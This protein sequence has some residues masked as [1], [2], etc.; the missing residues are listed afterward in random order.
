M[1]WVRVARRWVPRPIRYAVQRFVSLN[2]V[3]MRYF[4]WR[5][6]SARITS[7]DASGDAASV[8][9]G[10]VKNRAQYHTH[11]VDACLELQVP[12]RVIDLY[13]HDWLARVQ[14]A[15][16]AIHLA[17]P[18]ATSTPTAKVLK[19]RL[20]LLERDLGQQV[21]PSAAERW[22]YEDKIRTADWLTAHRLP[23]PATWVF[24][25]R[26]EAEAFATTCA[27]PIVT[28]TS[29]GA[30]ATGVRLLR[31]RRQVLATVA[32]AFGPGVTANGADRRDRQ[33]GRILLQ[34]HVD[35]LREW[36]MVRIGDA[37]FGHPKGRR[38]DF[39]SGSGTVAWDVPSPPLLDL[40]HEITELGRFRSMAVDVFETVTG[41]LLVN[42]LQTVFGAGTSVDQM[43][44]DGQP[45]RMIRGADGWRFEV[46]DFARNACANA[47]V[48]DALTWRSR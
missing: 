13:A 43:R 30:A 19:D 9:V 8:R 7:S 23:H 5:S 17:W 42:E 1:K 10:I 22:L 12:F 15:A 27:L 47:R 14:E 29:F 21:F 20:E 25:D 35:V 34:E 28:K 39:H 44:V 18:D 2:A 24:H 46:G 3:K 11:Y 31:R 26:A 16:C 38:G 40:L 4:E 45:G 32:Q 36:R 48:L 33:W 37:Y 41:R 6:P